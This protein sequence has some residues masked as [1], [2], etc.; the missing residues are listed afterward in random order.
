[1]AAIYGNK[2]LSRFLDGFLNATKFFSRSNFGY[3]RKIKSE[4][5]RQ[6]L[7][8]SFFS[9]KNMSLLKPK[10]GNYYCSEGSC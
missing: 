4:I 2:K 6:K 1:M 9:T 10:S 5:I 8:T 3:F 7:P